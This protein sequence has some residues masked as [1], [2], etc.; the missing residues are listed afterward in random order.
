LS[1]RRHFDAIIT[2]EWQRA[3]RE[4]TPVSLLMIDADRFK[5][6][7]DTHGHQSGDKVLRGIADCIADRTRR[8]TD[9]SAR[10]GG[11]EFALLLPGVEVESALGIAEWIC[12]NVRGLHLPSEAS[13]ATVSIGVAAMIPRHGMDYRE[14][15]D[16]A[17]KALYRAK[18]NGRDRCES[19]AQAVQQTVG[20]PRL[21]A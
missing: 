17:D 2:R 14:L 7:N 20:G 18:A 6:Y 8:A 21:V 1:N 16:A 10:Y 4:Q 19:I 12:K 13:P 9:L 15:I 5:P 11:D 3:T